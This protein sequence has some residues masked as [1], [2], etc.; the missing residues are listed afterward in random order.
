MPAMLLAAQQSEADEYIILS[1]G[2][3]DDG[4]SIFQ[5]IEAGLIAGNS[6]PKIHTVGFFQKGQ[7][8]NMG[9]RFLKR[10][11]EMTG[12]TYQVRRLPRQHL[13][14][15]TVCDYTPCRYYPNEIQKYSSSSEI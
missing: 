5:T 12:G 9:E 7:V 8:E 1:D 10:L 6:V 3:V 13:V 14:P 11:S 4:P 2:L 15:C